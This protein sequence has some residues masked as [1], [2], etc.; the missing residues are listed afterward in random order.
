MK[1]QIH[2]KTQTNSILIQRLIIVA[3]KSET[4]N[5]ALSNLEEWDYFLQ[6]NQAKHCTNTI[7]MEWI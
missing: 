7:L 4:K 5:K 1:S 6:N 3:N 2:L